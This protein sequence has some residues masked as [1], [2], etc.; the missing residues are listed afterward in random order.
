MI[1]IDRCVIPKISLALAVL[2]LISVSLNSVDA[3]NKPKNPK[4]LN[5]PAPSM[6]QFDEVDNNSKLESEFPDKNWWEGFNDLSLNNH[7]RVALENNY[8]LKAAALVIDESREL[9]RESFGHELPVLSINPAYTRQKNSRNMTTPQIEDFMGTGPK[10]FSPGS[11]V[12][13]ISMPLNASYE[14][15]FW[16][17]NRSITKVFKT[18][19]E[20]NQQNYKTLLVLIS[21]E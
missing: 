7:I 13:I 12:N 6:Q 21:T 17:K 5:L 4:D 9:V 18:R 10:L 1:M 14:A 3:K 2:F 8:D 15:D 11:S 19:Y 20:A 16:S